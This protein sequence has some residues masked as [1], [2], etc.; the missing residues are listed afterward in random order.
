MRRLRGR[1]CQFISSICL[2]ETCLRSIDPE[3]LQS[4]ASIKSR[5]LELPSSPPGPPAC[6]TPPRWS[7]TGTPNPIRPTTSSALDKPCSG[8]GVCCL[9]EVTSAT[10]LELARSICSFP[11]R[12]RVRSG[13]PTPKWLSLGGIQPAYH[14]LTDG[15]SSL[16]APKT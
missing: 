13:N 10:T 1:S 9:Q 15:Y 16:L 14:F 11:A 7:P 3:L 8:M 4:T 2:M 6:L 12:R 5:R